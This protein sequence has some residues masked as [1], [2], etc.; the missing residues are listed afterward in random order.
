M[1]QTIQLWGTPMAMETPISEERMYSRFPY[2]FSRFQGGP[3]AS[4]NYSF[5][6]LGMVRYISIY[7]YILLVFTYGGLHKW[8][9]SYIIHANTL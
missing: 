6:H 4:G 1:K 2:G 3:S 5:K 9:L 8:G 7:P